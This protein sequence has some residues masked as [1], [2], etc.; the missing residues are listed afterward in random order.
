MAKSDVAGWGAF[1]KVGITLTVYLVVLDL[2]PPTWLIVECDIEFK[3]D[4]TVEPNKVIIS[5]KGMF[6]FAYG[7]HLPMITG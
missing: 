1:L 2:S 4:Q 6:L 7:I 3:G 5:S